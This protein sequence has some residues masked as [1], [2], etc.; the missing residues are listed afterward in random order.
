MTR[1]KFDIKVND[2]LSY[3]RQESHSDR[4]LVLLAGLAMRL[5][6]GLDDERSFAKD[7]TDIMFA[8]DD[9]IEEIYDIT[10]NGFGRSA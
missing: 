6:E 1:N 9:N 4:R 5:K 7:V 3:T 2:E 10:L 8:P